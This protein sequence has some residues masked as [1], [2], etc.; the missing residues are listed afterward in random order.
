MVFA[1]A[2][3]VSRP[4]SS[5]KQFRKRVPA[6]IQRLAKGKSIVLTLPGG[7]PG[8]Q[9]LAVSV[10]LGGEITFSLRTSDPALVRRRHAAASGQL[11]KQFQALRDGFRRLNHMESVAFAGLAYDDLVKSFEG[12]PGT[13]T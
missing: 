13:T 12:F 3:P 1:M 10:T 8:Q 11:E 4:G 5:N 6:E 2:R 9:D 7:L